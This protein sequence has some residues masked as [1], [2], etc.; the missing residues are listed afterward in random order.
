MHVGS[1]DDRNRGLSPVIQETFQPPQASSTRCLLRVAVVTVVV[2]FP[3]WMM[4]G[5]FMARRRAM[6][7]GTEA[8]LRGTRV[9]YEQI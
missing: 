1:G 7:C 4:G 2:V 5:E 3:A 8:T 6:V 9:S